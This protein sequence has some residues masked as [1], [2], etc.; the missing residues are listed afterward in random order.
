MIKK[1][2]IPAYKQK[3]KTNR[4]QQSVSGSMATTCMASRFWYIGQPMLRIKGVPLPSNGDIL[5]LFFHAHKKQKMVND[6]AKGGGLIG[7]SLLVESMDSYCHR[8]EHWSKG[9]GSL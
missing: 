4:E 1:K 2:S 5:H 7:H 9:G 8:E 6:S 3:N